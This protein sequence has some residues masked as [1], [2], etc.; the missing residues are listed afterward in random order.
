MNLKKSLN[1]E[2]VR[3]AAM[4]VGADIVRFASAEPVDDE[5]RAR[6]QRWIERGDHATMDYL[7]RYQDVRDDP[8]L[9]LDGARTLIV[10]LFNYHTLDA[11][12]RDAS[13]HP[14]IAEYTVGRDYHEVIKA[15][16]FQLA[17][18]L[19]ET[20]GGEY[21]PCVDTAPL[22]ERYWAARAGAGFI[23]LNNQLTV[24]GR[25]S[26]FFIGTLVTTLQIEA[27][28]RADDDNAGGCRGCGRCVAACPTHALRGDGTL[29][30]RRCLSF[31]TIESRD[32][33][34][35]DITPGRRLYGCDQ[36]RLACPHEQAGAADYT[37]IAEF[38]PTD[39]VLSL[40][41]ADWASMTPSR[42]RK[43][44]GHSAMRRAG[45]QRIL[46]TLSRLAPSK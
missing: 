34:P 41:D 42:F 16:L 14:L 33:L 39:E 11:T 29:D 22:R 18:R 21:R 23:G 43:L 7:E 3:A 44:F 17:A 12:R 20:Y 36:C 2:D 5:A 24:P 6:Y 19:E 13:R 26:H 27:D 8:R 38:R 25:G 9:L 31:L 46:K 28:D 4:A 32:D 1:K 37:T 35:A 10:C 30:A 45:L 15:R 40:T